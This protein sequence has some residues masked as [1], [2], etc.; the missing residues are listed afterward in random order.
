MGGEI[1]QEMPMTQTGSSLTL[2]HSGKLA[3]P[4]GPTEPGRRW[5]NDQILNARAQLSQ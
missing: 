3:R 2:R 5:V 1:L 4:I